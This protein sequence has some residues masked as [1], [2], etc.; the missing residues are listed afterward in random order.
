MP[1]SAVLYSDLNCPFC[2]ALGERLMRLGLEGGVEWRGVQ[3]APMSPIPR[4][5]RN[6]RLTAMIDQ[7]VRVVRQLAP[8]VPIR[9][10][11][12]KPNTG[13]AILAIAAASRLDAE[14]GRRLRM[15]LYRGLWQC[16]EDISDPAVIA[17]F[18][19]ALGL[20]STAAE[21]EAKEQVAQ[22]GRAWEDTG[23]GSVPLL[24]RADGA[25]LSG[26]V[27]SARLRDFFVEGSVVV[28]ERAWAGSQ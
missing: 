5:E 7:E 19:E 6:S 1:T 26:L 9:T 10:L 21:S 15:N 23:A 16:N 13:P 14:L 22:W 24:V 25:L 11:T 8:E 27:S 4:V 20:A 28:G 2:Y 12:G 17:S 3:H 18:V